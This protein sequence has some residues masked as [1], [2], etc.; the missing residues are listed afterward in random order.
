MS[1]IQE[2]LVKG[3][4]GATEKSLKHNANSTTS[5]WAFQ[6]K[7]PAAIEKFKKH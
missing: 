6:P 5:G 2:K 3:F 4:I 7:T 1:K